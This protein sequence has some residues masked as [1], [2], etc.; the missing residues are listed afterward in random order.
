MK[1]SLKMWFCLCYWTRYML[2]DSLVIPTNTHSKWHV[3]CYEL[4]LTG[5]DLDVRIICRGAECAISIVTTPTHF[6][7]VP[8]GGI[9]PEYCIIRPVVRGWNGAF[10]YGR[11]TVGIKTLVY[12]QLNITINLVREL[13]VT[14]ANS[15]STR[16]WKIVI[17]WHKKRLTYMIGKKLSW[18]IMRLTRGST[19]RSKDYIWPHYRQEA[20]GIVEAVFQ[21]QLLVWPYRW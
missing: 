7:A 9:W 13:G 10:I 4:R 8:C 18:D 12:V 15:F 16:Y 20:W 19:G 5:R 3:H 17:S 11:A 6:C 1:C 21:L 2:D 14:F